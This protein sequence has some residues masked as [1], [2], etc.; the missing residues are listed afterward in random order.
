MRQ[1]KTKATWRPQREKSFQTFLSNLIAREYPRFGGPKIIGM[2]I[3]DLSAAIDQFYRPTQ[4]VSKGQ[5]LWV[6]VN[7]ADLPGQGKTMKN[8]Q[9]KALLLPFIT[10]QDIKDLEEGISLKK[11]NQKRIARVTLYAYENGALLSQ[12][13]LCLIFAYNPDYL[14]MMIEEYETEHN[15]ILPTRGTI[16]DL[17]AKVTHKKQIV[18]MHYLQNLKTPEIAK[19]SYHQPE[20]VDRYIKD[21]KRFK[22]CKDKNMTLAEIAFSTQMSLS[23]VKQYEQLLKELDSVKQNE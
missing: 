12:T 19:K 10:E 6:A 16:H 9:T 3:N 15:I 8:T 5:L 4:F 1:E 21:F 11:V 13:E 20:S 7:S 18:Q 17:G 22:F 14:R 23:L 2:F